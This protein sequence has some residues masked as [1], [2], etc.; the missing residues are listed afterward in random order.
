MADAPGLL[1]A[2][3]DGFAYSGSLTTPP[4]SEG[5]NRPVLQTPIEAPGGR[6][7]AFR[8]RIGPFNNRPLQ[9]RNARVVKDGV[10]YR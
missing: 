2:S 1:P 4:C 3:R 9:P 8:Q 10:S 7:A 6:I 5:V